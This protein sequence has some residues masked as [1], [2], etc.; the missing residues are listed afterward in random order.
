[1]IYIPQC[2]PKN[3]FETHFLKHSS[4]RVFKRLPTNHSI[5]CK[6][7]NFTNARSFEKHNNCVCK[8]CLLVKSPEVRWKLRAIDTSLFRYVTST[9]AWTS[10]TKEVTRKANVNLEYVSFPLVFIIVRCNQAADFI[11]HGQ[12]CNNSLFNV[13][14]VFQQ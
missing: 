11:G 13:C 6:T 2:F 9:Q 4:C 3:L 12:S 14:Y 1:M 7:V 8:E 5:F 10:N